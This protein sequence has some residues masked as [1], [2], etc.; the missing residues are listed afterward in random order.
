MAHSPSQP[1]PAAPHPSAP[2]PTRNRTGPSEVNLAP[3]RCHVGP[4]C[5]FPLPPSFSPALSARVRTRCRTAPVRCRSAA[6]RAKKM[7]KGTRIALPAHPLN[8]PTPVVPRSCALRDS[9]ERWS[10]R[11][12]SAAPNPPSARR[13]R[14]PPHR[15]L[16]AAISR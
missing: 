6:L 13:N 8:H 16:A 2:G 4:T 1:N 12:S 14:F 7:R 5:S 3:S 11:E 15:E 10:E 9:A